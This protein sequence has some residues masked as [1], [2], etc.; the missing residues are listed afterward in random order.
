MEVLK[1]RGF[2]IEPFDQDNEIPLRLDYGDGEF[3][4][5]LTPKEVLSIIN[6]LEKQMENLN[7]T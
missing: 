5:Y 4:V 7:K 1:L 3:V 6:F 2:E